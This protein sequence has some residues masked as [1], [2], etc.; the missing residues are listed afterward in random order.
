MENLL[1]QLLNAVVYSMLLFVLSAGLSLIFGQ[2]DFV[3]LCHGSFYL[4]GGYIGLSALRWLG[5]FWLALLVAPLAVGVLAFVLEVLVL[6]DLYG[7]ARHMDQVL[8]TFGV[9][10]ILE[11]AMRWVWGAQVLTIQQPELLR[12]SVSLF[13]GAFPVYRLALVLF[14]LLLFVALYLV[15]EKTR[16]GAIL[17]AGV[18]DAEMVTGLGINVE[19]V[20]AAVYSGGAALAAVAGVVGAPILSLAPGVDFEVLILALVVVV[21]G[22]LGSLAGAFAGSLIIGTV[23]VFGSAYLPAFSSFLPFA[24]MLLILHFRPRGLFGAPEV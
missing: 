5:N 22:G 13:G 15:I 2:M 8:F 3:N 23:Q 20:F 14:G 6:R 12:G 17:R 24:F 16:L 18:S 9:A 7:R 10:L 19:R 1:F 4:L 11:D 21:V